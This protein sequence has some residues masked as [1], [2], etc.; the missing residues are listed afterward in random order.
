MTPPED[1]GTC[2]DAARRNPALAA[3]LADLDAEFKDTSE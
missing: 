2:I 1:I 3:S